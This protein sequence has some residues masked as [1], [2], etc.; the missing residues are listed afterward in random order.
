ME[1]KKLNIL[2]T[3]LEET[4]KQSAYSENHLLNTTIKRVKELIENKFETE[5]NIGF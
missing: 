5:T 1:E 3:E 4:K 2:L